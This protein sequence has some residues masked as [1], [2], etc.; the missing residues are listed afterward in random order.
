MQELIKF[1]LNSLK[2]R[3]QTPTTLNPFTSSC[4]TMICKA[5]FLEGPEPRTPLQAQR[6]PRI[7]KISSKMIAKFLQYL[8]PLYLT[9]LYPWKKSL[10]RRIPVKSLPRLHDSANST[11]QFNFAIK[12]VPYILPLAEMDRL[13]QSVLISAISLYGCRK[14]GRSQPVLK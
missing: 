12:A 3:N 8:L 13:L 14:N 1:E 2:S 9:L 10:S 5:N 6:Y 4:Q 11:S 7:S